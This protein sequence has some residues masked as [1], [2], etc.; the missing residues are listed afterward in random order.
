VVKVKPVFEDPAVLKRLSF[1]LP[2]IAGDL[3]INEASGQTGRSRTAIKKFVKRYNE[4][5]VEGLRNKPR[6]NFKSVSP[7]VENTILELK[8]ERRSRSCRKI[9]DLAR[10]K[11]ITLHRQTI[12]RVLSKHGEQHREPRQLKPDKDFEYPEPNDC[13]QTDIMDGIIV[14]GVGLVY[15]HSFL[16]DHSRYTTGSGWFTNRGAKNI[17][18]VLKEALEINGLPKRIIADR[19]TQ[20]KN[21]LGPGL[22]HFEKILGR[23]GI[24]A[25]FASKGHPKTKGKKERYYRFV[26]EDF[27]SEYEFTS[28]DDL[29]SKWKVWT[30]WYHEEH[31]HSSLK[32]AT[33]GE[34]YARV[35]KRFSPF[36]LDDVFAT[37]V[38][39]KVRTNASV[40]FRRNVYLVDP[41]LIGQKVELRAFDNH[42]RIFHHGK[43]LGT[44]DA[45]IDYRER[46]LRQ[47]HVRIVNE[48]GIIRF[49]GK[50][51][52]VGVRFYRRRLELLKKGKEVHIFLPGNKRKVF[53]VH[54]RYRYHHQG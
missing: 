27:L 24:H 33:P 20:F 37:V 21:N 15:L 41:V 14:K 35:R 10:E 4:F 19:G 52:F 26:Q 16:D 18:T 28:V 5:G 53:K 43:I 36:P 3:T 48:E 17:L 54:R 39:R 13:W 49:R 29:N 2:I 1:V 44:Y 6:G 46:M 9:R 11:G 8:Q 25:I 40:S 42:V 7:D 45:R 32:G 51:Y 34:R 23:L 30:K 12:W 50:R 31:E 47:T 22:T 38:E